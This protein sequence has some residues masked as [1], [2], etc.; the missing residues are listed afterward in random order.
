[1]AKKIRL[2]YLA[3]AALSLMIGT[4]GL[5]V[6]AAPEET[7]LSQDGIQLEISNTET[8]YEYSDDN[9]NI[10]TGDN[11]SSQE[12]VSEDTDNNTPVI[13]ESSEETAENLY[14]LQ[15]TSPDYNEGYYQDNNI[16]TS[17]STAFSENELTENDPFE[18][19]DEYSFEESKDTDPIEVS[20]EIDEDTLTSE[21]WEKI[22]KGE[23]SVSVNKDK[24][25]SPFGDLKENN[26]G[27]NDDWIFLVF[28]IVSVSAGIL[29]IAAVIITTLI[30]KKKRKKKL[31]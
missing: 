29:I 2:K 16:Y 14:E 9:L 11:D 28:G 31:R 24:S 1:M 19:D 8:E 21:D 26:G 6:N 20:G 4:F 27:G 3:A 25:N 13:Q 7:E 12:Y 18:Y 5:A 15:E 23:V 22:K 30:S 10:N 17:V